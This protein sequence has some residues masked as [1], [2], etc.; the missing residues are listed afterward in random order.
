[1][2]QRPPG[3]HVEAV[4]AADDAE[5]E[6]RLSPVCNSPHCTIH[7]PRRHVTMADHEAAKRTVA[8]QHHEKMRQV[9]SRSA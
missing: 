7:N 6:Q 4:E 5:N 2:E 3:A 8:T 9:D 1:V